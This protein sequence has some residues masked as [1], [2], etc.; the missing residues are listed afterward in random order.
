M[1]E[2]FAIAVSF[3]FFVRNRGFPPLS[4]DT[5]RAGRKQRERQRRGGWFLEKEIRS[6]FPRKHASLKEKNLTPSLLWLCRVLFRS[7]RCRRRRRRRRRRRPSPPR[8]ARSL[9]RRAPPVDDNHNDD[10]VF[11]RRIGRPSGVVRSQKQR[12]RRRR[13]RRTRFSSLRRRSTRWKSLPNLTT[14]RRRKRMYRR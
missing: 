7:S 4:S 1:E 9:R 2:L 6:F 5:T 11:E 8:A 13:R 3:A 12:R 10:E 14:T